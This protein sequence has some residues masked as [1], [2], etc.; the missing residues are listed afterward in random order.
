MEIIEHLQV[1][2]PQNLILDASSSRD[3]KD[4]S[5]SLTY[6]WEEVAGPVGDSA[7]IVDSSVMILK[8][9]QPG[10]YTYRWVG[11]TTRDVTLWLVLSYCSVAIP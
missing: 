1:H 5:E 2:L 3:D 10:R 8:D 11:V 4:V 9:L 6:H 7:H